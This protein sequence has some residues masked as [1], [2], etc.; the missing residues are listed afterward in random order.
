MNEEL[1]II[2]K[3]VTDSAKKGIKDIS[4]E[5]DG[6]GK[7]A[8]GASAKVGE[9]MK[10]I[11][12]GAL[13]A[14]GAIA[15]VGAALV[16]LGKN[17]LE[18]NK[19]QAKLQTAFLAAGASAQQATETYKG[20]YRFLGDSG[21]ATE[22]AAHLAKMTTNQQNLAQWTKIAQGV[23]ATFGDSLPIE[24]LTEAANE[25]IRVG[26]VTG[27]LAD[28]LNWA[29]VSE[30]EFNAKLAATNSLEER[31][32]LLRSTLNGLY[33]DA[34]NI[35]EKNNA[36]LLD[37]Q[38]SQAQ[39]DIS[40]GA[41]G[42]AVLPLMTALNNLSS[43]FFTA[44]KPA[45]DAIIP[46]IAAFI[47]MIAKGIELVMSFFSALTGKSSKIKAV[48]NIGKSAVGGLGSAANKTGN[49][50]SG[51]GSAAD[52]ADDLASGL[53]DAAK[54]AEEAK[55]STMGF[56]ELNIVSSGT[57]G[58]VGTSGGGGSSSKGGGGGGSG[59]GS[60]A[61]SG[62]GGGMLDNAAFATEVEE[63]EGIANSLA[64]KIKNA[65][66]GLKDV[67]APTIEAWSGAFETIKAAWE[68]AKPSFINGANEIIL[69][70]QS[71]GNYLI[72]DFVP[73]VVNTFSVNLA[74]VV[75]DTLGFAIEQSGKQ[76][77]WFGGLFRKTTNDI[78]IPALNIIKKTNTDTFN[79]IGQAW[80]THGAGLLEQLGSFYENVRGHF[81]NLYNV[82]IKP[83]WD[84]IVAV[85]IEAWD[86]GIKPMVDN[87]VNSFIEIQTELLLLYNETIAPIVNWIITNIVPIIVSSVNKVIEIIGILVT[88]ISDAISGVITIL[89]GIIQ[90]IVGVFTLDWG[91]AWEGIKNI[92]GGVW[93]I[94]VGLA[95]AAWN[96]IKSIF[97]P[98][99]TFFSGCWNKITEAFS[100]MVNW[101]KEKFDQGFTAIKNAFSGVGA[102]FSG[103]WEGIKSTFSHVTDWFKDT[104]S[105]AWTAVKNVFCTGGKIFD[106]IKEGIANVFKT[107]VNGIIR[108]INK[109]IK[110]PFDAINGMLNKLRNLEIA[111]FKPF[112][113][114]IRTLSVPQ[115]PLL[116]KGGVVDSATV[117]MIGEAGKEAVVPL[118]RNTEWMDA[119]ADKIASRTSSPS[120]IVLMLDGRELGWA[121]IRSINGIT[122]Q[123]GKLQ[124]TLV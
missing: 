76:F 35:Y 85:F 111:G 34:A 31:E 66:A 97:E 89:K 39:L 32:A 24:G 91:K 98:I 99:G 17:T 81:D 79:I 115:I 29:G 9:A 114:F 40:M 38:A 75:G 6:L 45:L 103:V 69:G 117:A 108:G 53:D 8:K 14:V 67:F 109:I 82:V 96:T 71:L 70:F 78:I 5:I 47:N 54:A 48:S 63:S 20:F 61:Y 64:E 3:A 123:T 102:F 62:G 1:K 100:N 122:K 106:G 74:P 11:G 7:G 93:D 113:G 112:S 26:Q 88:F 22:A 58:S 50:A 77:E 56:D 87:L 60:P 21:Q 12:K 118:D 37:Y 124:L 94:I 13:I 107:V 57:S 44:L 36:A 121:N 2:I 101:F 25:S 15:A 23:Y 72:S 68:N 84:K 52:G 59:S 90:F 4:K 10:A 19:E 86:N 80:K 92:F 105:K 116:A 18:F 49:L 110:V 28:A 119:L 83:I 16:V 95:S 41:A 65:F 27:T 55:K 33:E 51:L 42:A 46:P 104:F 73:S 120:K 43:A 30:D